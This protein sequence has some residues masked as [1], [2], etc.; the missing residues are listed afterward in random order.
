MKERNLIGE[1]MDM[2]EVTKQMLNELKKMLQ[3]AERDNE[4]FFGAIF[5]ILH[6]LIMRILKSLPNQ[7]EITAISLG[8]LIAM[9]CKEESEDLFEELEE[10][11]NL[12]EGQTLIKIV[13]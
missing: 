10:F 7:D 4:G 6:S 1:G 9:A 12:K 13:H 3:D 2:Q 5:L 8:Y 11:K